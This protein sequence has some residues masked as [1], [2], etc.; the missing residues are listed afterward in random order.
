MRKNPQRKSIWLIAIYDRSGDIVH[1]DVITTDLHSA[2]ARLSQTTALRI[3]P[4]P[5]ERTRGF[6]VLYEADAQGKRLR[7]LVAR[8]TPRIAIQVT[9]SGPTGAIV[10]SG[11]HN[12]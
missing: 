7:G 2:L 8:A 5:A 11:D 10:Q 4:R 9:R 12:Y 3:P 1:Q 6:G